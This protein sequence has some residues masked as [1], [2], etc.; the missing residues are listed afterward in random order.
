M[1]NPEMACKS[2]PYSALPFC[3]TSLSVDDRVKDLVSRIKDTDKPDLLTARASK[4]LPDIGVPAYYWGTN[5]IHSVENGAHGE[6]PNRCI[7]GKCA[8]FFPNPP[9]WMSAFNRTSMRAMAS[10][11]AKELRG[12]YNIQYG[13]YATSSHLHFQKMCVREK[14]CCKSARAFFLLMSHD[15][16]ILC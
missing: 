10:T 3:D 12:L 9:N 8:T 13:K 15:V 5:C 4:P 11:M 16:V 2:A 7:D 6:V 14:R 1:P